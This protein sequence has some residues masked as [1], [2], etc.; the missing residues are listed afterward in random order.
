[1]RNGFFILKKKFENYEAEDVNFYIQINEIMKLLF[2]FCE[3][4]KY[5]T[6]VFSMT[7][8][9]NGEL[10]EPFDNDFILY[11]HGGKMDEI[12]KDLKNGLQWLLDVIG[13][14]L[15]GIIINKIEKIQV[16]L[17]KI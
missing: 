16:R 17:E 3:K 13:R 7:I 1:M 2:F 15:E 10:I 4:T 8:E 14:E 11:E 12:E 5:K 9:G 6:V